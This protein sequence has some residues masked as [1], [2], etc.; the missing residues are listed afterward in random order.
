[1]LLV[2]LAGIAYWLVV[3]PELLPTAAELSL[4]QQGQRPKAGLKAR[5]SSD[6]AFRTVGIQGVL[7]HLARL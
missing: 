4:G 6:W 2:P 1:V 3:R 5:S 7:H